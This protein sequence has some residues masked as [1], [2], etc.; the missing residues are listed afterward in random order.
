MGELDIYARLNEISAPPQYPLLF[1]N[2]AERADK[3]AEHKSWLQRIRKERPS[4]A[5][6]FKVG[7]YIKLAWKSELERLTSYAL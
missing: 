7:I 6:P 3:I 4:T 2:D 5:H 1:G